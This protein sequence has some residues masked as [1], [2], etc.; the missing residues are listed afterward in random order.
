[1]EQIYASNC[2]DNQEMVTWEN[3][4]VLIKDNYNQAK[5][6]FKTLVKDFETYTQN[7]CGRAAK[8]SYK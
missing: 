7:S 2:F 8:T 4:P 6:Y 1:M 3:K 5:L